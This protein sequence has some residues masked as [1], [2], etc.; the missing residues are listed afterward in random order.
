MRTPTPLLAAL[1]ASAAAIGLAVIVPGTASAAAT[2]LPSHVF[3]PYFEAYNGDNPVTLSQE[4]GAKYLTFAFIQTAS[5]GSCTAYWNGDSGEPLTSATFGSD[6]A[7]IQADGGNVIP[8]FGGESADNSGTD[9]ADSCTSV[10][11]IAQVYE[12]VITTYNVPRID[13]DIEGDSLTD[14]AGINRRNEAVAQVESWAAANGRS[15]QFSYTMP[16]TTTGLD[17]S[18]VSILQNAIADGAT[19]SVVNLMTFDYY[20]GTEQEMATD[21]ESA[22]AGL[23]GQLQDLY[24]SDTSAQLWAKVGVTEMPGIDDYGP[25]ETFTEADASTVLNWAESNGIGTLSFWALQRDNGGCPGTAGSDTCSGISQPTWYFS[26][27]FEPFISSASGGGSPTGPIV[28]YE[29]LC[30]DDRGASTANYNPVQVY[31]CNG[32]DAQQ[33]TVAA[34]NTLQV[35]GKCLDIY[36]G[37]TANGTQVDLYSCN[38]TGAQVWEPQSDGALLNPQSGKCLDDT[39]WGGSGTQLQIWACTGNANQQWTLP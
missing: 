32:T 15:I 12:N 14:T 20:I 19:V 24:P 31:T 39:G 18:E 5:A 23:H 29:G 6:I 2:P 16:A 30:V 35:L 28:G 13:L 22:A 27:A 7:T 36:A 4:S 10:S 8:S 38:G 1:A 11:S 34:G 26:D 21:T 9:I 37:G 25:D 17:S 3:A 33:W